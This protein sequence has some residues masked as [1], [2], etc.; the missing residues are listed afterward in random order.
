MSYIFKVLILTVIFVVVIY[1]YIFRKRRKNKDK[2]FD[3][4]KEYHEAFERH[5]RSGRRS[6]N[7]I[8]NYVTK[9]NSTEDYRDKF[10][11]TIM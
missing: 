6:S 8:N 3:S 10:D 7:G 2:T 4:V 9:Y 1:I 11:Q 5:R